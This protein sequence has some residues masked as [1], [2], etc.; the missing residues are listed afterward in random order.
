MPWGR[1]LEGDE[2]SIGPN[3]ALPSP[4]FRTAVDPFP[5]PQRTIK[6]HR[7]CSI[8]FI[9]QEEKGV[10]L[11]LFIFILAARIIEKLMEIYIGTGEPSVQLGSM[12]YV[13]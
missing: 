13:K 10:F 2:R 6:H 3:E 9:F 8:S 5:P 4:L 11:F 12:A 7:F 1:E